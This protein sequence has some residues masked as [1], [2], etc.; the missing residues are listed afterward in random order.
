M[1]RFLLILC[2]VL[3]MAPQ[4]SLART[5]Y[6]KPDG[7]GDA[8]T[9]QAGLDSASVG[10]TVLVAAGVYYERNIA[11]QNGAVLRSESG[12]EVTTIDAEHS[13]AGIVCVNLESSDT[14]IEEFTITGANDS[15]VKSRECSPQ[16]LGNRFVENEAELGAGISCYYSSA[17]IEGNTFTYNSATANG[18][19]I[20]CYKGA[21][22]IL[23]NRVFVNS[24]GGRGG[25]MHL[26]A[27]SATVSQNLIR[28]NHAADRGGGI[29]VRTDTLFWCYPVIEA[30]TISDNSAL[31]GGGI[32]CGG[33]YVSESILDNRITRN[34]ARTDG[35]GVYWH[36]KGGNPDALI[37][38]NVVSENTADQGG[39]FY[40]HKGPAS[41]FL[42]NN[43]LFANQAQSGGGIYCYDRCPTISFNII[44]CSAMGCG[45]LCDSS[46]PLL[47]CNDIYGNAGG[48]DF[49]GTD[50]GGNFSACPSF[51][52][53]DGGSFILCDESPCAPG[54]HPYGYDCGIIGA[55]PVGCS[56][57]QT[58]TEPA[59]WGAIKS[60]YR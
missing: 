14:K 24:A 31:L 55:F 27:C 60:M 59:T 11:M 7:T 41:L 3:S 2:L 49:C 46:N 10:D 57:S 45:L 35:G 20:R 48:D 30:N 29:H 16:I 52:F 39:G 54:N 25:G 32:F 18:G 51:C 4:A 21:P 40:I 22:I 5:W 23:G 37:A 8:P 44:A 26:A 53:A 34:S 56:C 42:Q 58:Q 36:G 47:S 43:T 13:G 50:N 19:A 12:Y 33:D 17:R 1:G 38:G 28:S 6:I 9:I 15:A